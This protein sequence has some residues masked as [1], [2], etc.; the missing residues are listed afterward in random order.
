MND[1]VLGSTSPYRR[2]LLTRLAVPFDAIAPDVDEESVQRSG[3]E[4]DLVALRL[5]V[6]KTASVARHRS[7]AYVIGS[8]QVAD[9]DGEILGKPGHEAGAVEQLGRLAGRTHR[10]VTALALRAPDGTIRTHVDVH[11]MT[12]RALNPAEIERY[13]SRDQPLDCCGAYKIEGLGISLFER[14]DGEDFTA[15][16]GLPLIA[17][18]R[19]LREAGFPVP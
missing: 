3:I 1:L 6:A 2:E 16:T 10:L 4:P 17:L 5:A 15:I 8:D 19:L 12:L 18:G 9:L 7:N 13:V 11:R 14:I